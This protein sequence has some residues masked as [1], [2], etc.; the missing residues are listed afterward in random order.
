MQPTQSVPG[1]SGLTTPPRFRRALLGAGLL[2]VGL[3]GT[4][5]AD[6]GWDPARP[7]RARVGFGLSLDVA[8]SLQVLGYYGYTELIEDNSLRVPIVL[9]SG[10]RVEPELHLSAYSYDDEKVSDITLA[11]ATGP[12][13]RVAP[14]ATGYAGGRLAVHHFR[15]D[16]E[17][18]TLD[19]TGAALLGG[20]Q[21]INRNLSVGGEVWLGYTRL[22]PDSPDDGLSTVLDIGADILFRF[23]LR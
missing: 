12:S 3:L 16:T 13:W 20:E 18:A 19:L 22:D 8:S 7:E 4:A 15:W 2:G 17:V 11:V 23:Y 10:W 1:R 6:E 14:H 5:H 21:W 9:P